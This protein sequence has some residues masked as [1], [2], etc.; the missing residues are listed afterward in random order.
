MRLTGPDE[1]EAMSGTGG[2]VELAARPGSGMTRVFEPSDLPRALVTLPG[3]THLVEMPVE[4][5]WAAHVDQ[6]GA[7]IGADAFG[8]VVDFERLNSFRAG[9]LIFKKPSY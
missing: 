4:G 6:G 7:R 9:D 8:H 5:D 3:R 2:F 1:A